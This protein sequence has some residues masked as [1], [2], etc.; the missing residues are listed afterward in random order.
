[1]IRLQCI[2]SDKQK[3][4]GFG[5]TAIHAAQEPNPLHGAV[6][7]GIELATTY[8]QKHQEFIVDL[9]IHEP[10]IQLVLS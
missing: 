5:T 9:N 10:Q 2:L 6:I 4:E 1:M 8:A 3:Y 7:P